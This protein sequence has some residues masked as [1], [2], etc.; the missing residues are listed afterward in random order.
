MI[1]KSIDQFCSIRH[2]LHDNNRLKAQQVALGPSARGIWCF[3]VKARW[4]RETSRT[5][6]TP[7]MDQSADRIVL[8]DFALRPYDTR[9]IGWL[10][11]SGALRTYT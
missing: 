1:V 10:A 3:G 6:L 2:A 7:S 8:I 11:L 4:R 9:F 5:P